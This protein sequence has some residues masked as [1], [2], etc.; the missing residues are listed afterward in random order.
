MDKDKKFFNC[1]EQHEIKYLASK[2]QGSK[3][4]IV[5][6]IKRL[7]KEKKIKYSTHAEAENI[8]ISEGFIKK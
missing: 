2:F 7:C 3:E 5:A 1:S 6:A 8:L 4:E